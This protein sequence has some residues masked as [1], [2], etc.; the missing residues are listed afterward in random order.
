[1]PDT[2]LAIHLADWSSQQRLDAVPA[3]ALHSARRAI[4]DTTGVIVAGSGHPGVR[5]LAAHISTG[6][7]PCLAATGV[8]TD[9]VAAATI[10][11]MAAR[12]YAKDFNLEF[13]TAAEI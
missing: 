4:L 12:Y 2:P 8:A 1:M 11:G 6:T 9:P 10:N 7:G 3:S 13:K 5:A